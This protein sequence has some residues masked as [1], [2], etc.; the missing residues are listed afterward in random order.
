MQNL[1]VDNALRKHYKNQEKNSDN[2]LFMSTNT[3]FSY[4][5]STLNRPKQ[6]KT[7]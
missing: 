6:L 7:A 5:N 1:F 3:L 4:I 2:R